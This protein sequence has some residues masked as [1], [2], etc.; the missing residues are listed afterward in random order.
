[1]AQ[2]QI[3]P[4]NVPPIP[5]NLKRTA[6]SKD[7]LKDALDGCKRVIKMPPKKTEEAKAKK[8]RPS[9]ARIIKVLP[10][11]DQKARPGS[12]RALLINLV[13]QCDGKTV[14]A[15]YDLT[16]EYVEKGQLSSKANG[17]TLDRM[18]GVLIT[19]SDPK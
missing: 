17:K 18:I 19:V 14:Q 16:Q 10:N 12:K 11:K 4:A 7:A 6:P 1:M 8:T 5:K 13:K 3:N 15:Y 2:T 9:N